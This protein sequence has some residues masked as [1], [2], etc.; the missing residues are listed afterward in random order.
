[1]KKSTKTQQQVTTQGT[2]SVT[3]NFA[4]LLELKNRSANQPKTVFWKRADNWR[5]ILERQTGEP[6]SDSWEEYC[7]KNGIQTAPLAAPANWQSEGF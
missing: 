4:D 7:R 6:I 1:M 5:E 3:L 2:N